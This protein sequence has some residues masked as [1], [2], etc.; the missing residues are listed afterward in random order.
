LSRLEHTSTLKEANVSINEIPVRVVGPG[1][2]PGDG[3][4]PSYIDLPGD[5]NQ[6]VVPYI[7]NLDAVRRLDGARAAMQ[8]LCQALADYRCGDEPML[9]NLSGLDSESRELVNQILGEG[10]V[11]VVVNDG[12]SIQTQEAVL[13]GVWRTF[14]FDGDGTVNFDLLEVADAPLAAR[15]VNEA[16]RPIDKSV[17]DGPEAVSNAMPILVELESQLGIYE[18]EG[19]SHS[20]NLSLLPMSEPELEFLAARLGRGPVDV[21]S[22]AYGKCQISS[23]RTPNIWWVRYYNS[24]ESLILNSL[25]VID[26]PAVIRAADEDLRDSAQ[27]LDE[28]L[29]P[30]WSDVA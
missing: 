19:K 16:G 9:V 21:L 4:A 30:Y 25:E 20:I 27:R 24:M 2:Q 13:A 5:I 26:I 3:Q 1:S 12:L 18:S 7:P 29:A 8:W 10:E 11:S 17:P 28:I 22:R 6:Y 15:V 23:T 14:G